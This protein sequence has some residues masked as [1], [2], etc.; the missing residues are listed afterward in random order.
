MA[1]PVTVNGSLELRIDESGLEATLVFSPDP[2]GPQWD[3][4]KINALLEQRGVREG[5]ESKALDV[6]FDPEKGDSKRIIIVARGSEPQESR[7]PELN[8]ERLAVP[9]A[10]KPYEDQVIPADLPPLV[11]Q[12]TVEKTKTERIVTKKSKLPFLPAKEQKQV[13]WE[14]SEKLTPLEQ[15]GEELGRGYARKTDVVATITPARRARAGRDVFG[16][17]IPAAAPEEKGG[18]YL[19]EGLKQTGAEIRADRGGFYRYGNNWIELFPFSLHEH[20]VYTSENKLTCLLDFTPGSDLATPP[21]ADQILEEAVALGFP[22]AELL[23]VGQLADLLSRALTEKISL[24]AEPV[25]RSSDG[26]IQ[27]VISED[28]LKAHLNLRKATGKGKPLSLRQAGEVIRDRKLKG[29]DIPRTQEDILD[30][31]RGGQSRLENYLLVEGR[32]AQRGVDGRIEWRISFLDDKRLVELKKQAGSRSEQLEEFG[33]LATFPM[34]AVQAMAEVQERATVAEIIPATAG[35]AG[36]DVFGTVLP[37]IKGQDVQVELFENLK[38]VG[39]ELITTQGGLLDT[40]ENEG[41]LMMRVRPH[42]D[43]EIQVSLIEDRMQAF[44]TLLPSEGTGKPLDPD[45]VK[46]VIAEAG[47]VKG[48]QTEELAQALE[49]GGTGEPV[50]NLLIA[51]G[52]EPRAGEDTDLEILVRL[53]SGRRLTLREDGR[54]DYRSQDKITVVKAGDLLATLKT[55]TAGSDGWD[56]TG[57]TLPA[58]RG[59]ARYVHAGKHVDCREEEDGSLQYFAKIDGELDY[60]GSSIDVLQIHNVEGNVGLESGNVKFAGTVRVTGSVQSGFSVVSGES[61]F[62]EESVQGAF[63]SAGDSIRIEKGVAGENKAVLRANKSIRARFA[64]QATLLAVENIHLTNSCLRCTVKCNG[65]MIL[66]SEKGN[67]VGGRVY[68]KL[69]LEAMN[70]GSEREVSTEIH[71]GQDILIQD[72]MERGQRQSEQLKKRNAEI[73]RSLIHLKRTSPADQKSLQKLN[74]EKHRNLQ[75]MQM[76]SK[77]MFILAER[78][79]QHFPSEIAVRGVVY[80]GVVLKS[81]GRQRE[82]RTALREVVFFFNTTTGRIEEKPLNE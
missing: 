70:L 49:R 1:E 14:K 42:Q 52:Q 80:P 67:V 36:V 43:R 32:E 23:E 29:L 25:S 82:V 77:R 73:E 31:H 28:K 53:A 17:E 74:A 6:L 58:R 15:P 71:F 68:C 60:R 5:V 41:R 61:I 12:R 8:V 30:F 37:G 2:E 57:K 9:E 10:L 54:A 39:R 75:Q 19:S 7:A 62:V 40:A 48:L 34:E 78:L 76:H 72:Q 35:A 26:D 59:S 79:E 27:V 56:V 13:V 20:R 65:K 50:R 44:L 63:L 3:P 45:E 55:P 4:Q 11:Y 81:H 46:R 16:K 47:V 69:G 38:Q 18:P 22:K 33:S 24:K 64:E 21:T 66:E 51:Q